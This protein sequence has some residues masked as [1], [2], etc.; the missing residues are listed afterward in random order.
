[1]LVILKDG[2]HLARDRVRAEVDCPNYFCG[3]Q[4]GSDCVGRRRVR[5]QLHADRWK[6]WTEVN[7]HLVRV[8]LRSEDL[9]PAVTSALRQ[10][11]VREP[12]RHGE[13]HGCNACLE[14]IWAESAA[15]PTAV[16]VPEPCEPSPLDYLIEV[17]PVIVR[18]VTPAGDDPK[19]VVIEGRAM[20]FTEFLAYEEAAELRGGSK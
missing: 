14:D 2:G 3:A 4:P 12:C 8:V 15:R 9:T 10:V 20:T 11:E 13:V 1:M 18:D 16:P 17:S 5:E 7:S 6:R 19:I